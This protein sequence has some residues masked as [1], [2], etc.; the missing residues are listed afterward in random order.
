MDNFIQEGKMKKTPLIAGTLTALVFAVTSPTLVFAQTPSPTLRER[1][2]TRIETRQEN[3]QE[4]RDARAQRIAERVEKRFALHD[5]HIT[6]WIARAESRVAKMKEN[7]KDTTAAE[8]GLTAAKA[9]FANAQKLG[10]DAVAQLKAIEAQPWDEQKPDVKAAK[11]AVR[12]AQ[13]AY[14]QVVKDMQKVIQ[15]LLATAKETR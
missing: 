9:S 15:A 8:K 13:V 2:E 3:R 4:L 11:E 12:K 5:A 6:A 7:G 1:V 10:T 14:A